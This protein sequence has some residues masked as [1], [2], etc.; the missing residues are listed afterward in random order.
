MTYVVI[1]VGF[2]LFFW[3]LFTNTTMKAAASSVALFFTSAFFLISLTQ[4]EESLRP[5]VNPEDFLAAFVGIVFLLVSLVL[6]FL[7]VRD[8]WRGIERTT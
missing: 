7:N 4:R 8:L 3:G 5:L 1:L 2:A 6:G